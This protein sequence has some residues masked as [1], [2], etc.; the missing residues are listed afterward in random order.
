M[1]LEIIRLH[2]DPFAVRSNK[3]QNTEE[4]KEN[5]F[6]LDKTGQNVQ[7]FYEVLFFKLHTT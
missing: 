6:K 4:I 2:K 3:I 1:I 5:A 7:I